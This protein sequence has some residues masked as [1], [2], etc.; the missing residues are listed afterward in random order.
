MIKP[1]EMAF[2]TVRK[3]TP[4]RKRNKSGAT[5]SV[6]SIACDTLTIGGAMVDLISMGAAVTVS[7]DKRSLD[8]LKLVSSQ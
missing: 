8:S 6:P 5:F 2:G 3:N 4:T 1:S 7:I